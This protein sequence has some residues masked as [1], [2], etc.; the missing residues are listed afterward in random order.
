[1]TARVVVV[2]VFV[3]AGGASCAGSDSEEFSE[4]VLTVVDLD[5]EVQGWRLRAEARSPELPDGSPTFYF[6][7]SE[8]V[9]G[10]TMT[11]AENSLFP[12]PYELVVELAEPTDGEAL[13][14]EAGFEIFSSQ[15]VDLTVDAQSLVMSEPSQPAAE[16]SVEILRSEK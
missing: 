11:S 14:C 6:S 15:E 12:R 9:D 8:V 16:C 5:D 1:M 13:R 7:D 4:V 10:S 2:T 3:L